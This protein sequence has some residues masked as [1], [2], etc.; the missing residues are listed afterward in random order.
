MNTFIF[1]P[2]GTLFP[3]LFPLLSSL[4]SLFLSFFHL[5][6]C[7]PTVESRAFA[8]SC[9]PS[10]SD[11]W[12]ARITGMLHHAQFIFIFK[13]RSCERNSILVLPILLHNLK[14]QASISLKDYWL[15]DHGHNHTAEIFLKL[16]R[17]PIGHIIWNTAPLLYR[18]YTSGNFPKM[19]AKN[20]TLV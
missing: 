5:V 20:L 16:F 17:L 6:F 19:K 14:K 2:F 11:S 7:V 12:S 3:S 10:S 8:L 9:D 1:F 18:C 13:Y 4:T 15:C